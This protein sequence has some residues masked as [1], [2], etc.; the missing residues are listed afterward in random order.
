VGKRARAEAVF[1]Q[2]ADSHFDAGEDYLE[3][4]TAEIDEDLLTNFLTDVEETFG[5]A[6]AEGKVW[7][8]L[9]SGTPLGALLARA[10]QLWDGETLVGVDA[11]GTW[12]EPDQR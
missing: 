11:D 12:V 3:V 10:V 6:D 1:A 9:L 4:N 8:N 5:I 7:G 2:I